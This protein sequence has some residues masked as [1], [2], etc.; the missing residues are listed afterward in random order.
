M[1]KDKESKMRET[2][3]I[4]GLSGSVYAL[5]YMC[6]QCAITVI[7]SLFLTLG[8][9]FFAEG[10]VSVGSGILLF[11]ATWL[12]SCGFIG[13]S[14]ILQ[15]FFQSSKLAPMAGPLILFLPTSISTYSIL[16]PISSGVQNTWVQYLFWI[17][18]FPYEVIVCNLFQP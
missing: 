1:V 16:G 9:C 11:L 6:Y 17:P 7:T 18:T 15:N 4:M 10:A 8:T 12:L 2:L 5:S 3:K 13:M 14:L